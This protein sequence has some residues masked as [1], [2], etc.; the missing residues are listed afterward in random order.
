MP[1]TDFQK[2]VLN[3]IRPFRTEA[4]YVGGGA[5][6]NRNWARI[7]DDMDIF[8][9]R[10]ESLPDK[11]A[12][13]LECLRDAGFAIELTVEDAGTVEAIIKKYGFE[14]LVQWMDDEETS[15]R[16]F[17]AVDDDEFGFRLH[18]ADGAVN[19]VLCAAR[20][21][22]AARDAVDLV[23]I[24][25][26]Y[27]PLG[28]LIW[29]VSG[30]DENMAPPTTIQNIRRNIF[31]YADEEI[32]AVRME[33]ENATRDIIRAALEPALERASRYC[34]DEAPVE[35]L[36]ELFVDAGDTPMEADDDALASGRARALSIQNFGIVPTISA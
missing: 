3:V 12:M 1:L 16:F 32:R 13:E 5:A 35:R 4:N 21:N 22:T 14:T 29:A 15:Q 18:Q 36:G 9:D 10:R 11:V 6:L 28:P 25:E 31:G 17:P 8:H 19:K 33:G 20:R 30:K 26:N 7:S 24:S 23:T 2:S 34:S 27:A